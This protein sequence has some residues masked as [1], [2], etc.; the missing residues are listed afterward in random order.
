LLKNAVHLRSPASHDNHSAP[1]EKNKYF[2]RFCMAFHRV[3][4]VRLNFIKVTQEGNAPRT[5]VDQRLISM[6]S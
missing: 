5:E 4:P 3:D 1:L 6:P 2:I